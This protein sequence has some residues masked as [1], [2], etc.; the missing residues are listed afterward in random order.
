MF[1]CPQSIA[2]VPL[3]PVIAN[4]PVIASKPAFP[5]HC[6]RAEGERSNLFWLMFAKDRRVGA[7][8]PPRDDGQ[9][10]VFSAFLTKL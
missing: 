2:I 4:P 1:N 8:A 7:D 9:G 3:F 5:H 10:G 6:E